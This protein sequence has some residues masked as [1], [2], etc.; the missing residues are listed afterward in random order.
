MRISPSSLTPTSETVATY[1]KNLRR[2]ANPNPRPF[3]LLFLAR[4]DL[5][6]TISMTFRKRPVS[7]GIRS[8][9]RTV[10]RKSLNREG[11]IDIA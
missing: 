1:V 10:I 4:P 8:V 3:A 5:S 11:K 6:T 9:I 7:P 2:A